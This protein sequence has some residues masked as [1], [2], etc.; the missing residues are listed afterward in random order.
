MIDHAFYIPSLEGSTK[1]L[2]KVG[3]CKHRNEFLAEAMEFSGADLTSKERRG[4]SFQMESVM[5][6]KSSFIFFNAELLDLETVGHEVRHAIFWAL[7]DRDGVFAL[8]VMD[9]EREERLNSLIDDMTLHVVQFVQQRLGKKLPYIHGCVENQAYQE[10]I[11]T[12]I[13]E[14]LD[15]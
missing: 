6:I 11:P 13:Q 12:G 9:E 15:E 14:L 4:V 1:S 2:V 10:S 8:S 7:S 3:L 5:A